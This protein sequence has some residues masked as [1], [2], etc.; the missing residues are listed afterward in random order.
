M[1]KICLLI[2]AATII[3]AACNPK[4]KKMSNNPL[5]NPFD[6]PFGIPPFEKIKNADY[7]PAFQE[8]IKLHNDEI[9]AIVNSKEEP[10][11]KNTIEALDF[12]GIL[13]SDIG[14]I[15]FALKSANTNDSI[16]KIAEEV[17]P[18]LAGHS[19]DI[20]LNE[21]LFKK[22]KAV[23]DKRESLKLNTEQSVLLKKTYDR[24]VRGGANLPVD[25]K[26]RFREINQKLSILQLKFGDNLV[27]ENNAF[28]LLL[29]KKEDLAGLPE[30]IISAAKEAAEAKGFKGKWLFTLDNPSR[31]PFLTYS[32][33]RDLREKI[34]RGYLKKGDNNNEYDNKKIIVEL[35]MLRQEKAKMLGYNNYA[36]YVIE[37]NMAKTPDKVFEMLNKVWSYTLPAVKKEAAELQKLIKSEGKTFKLEGWDW[38]YYSEK[39]RKA[40]YD[41]D[42][43]ATRPYFKLDNVK[44][45]MFLLAN[46]LY[47][48]TFEQ[49]KNAP[50]YSNEATVYEV[51]E[52]DGKHIGVF[53]MDPFPR[54]NKRG[55][56][57]MTNFRDQ[58]IMD[59]KET[60]PIV[61]NVCNFTR[62]TGDTP[63]LLTLD[64]VLTMFHEFGHG[65]HGLLSNCTYRS[66]SGTS[67]PRDFVEFGSQIMENWVTEPEFLKMYAKHYQTGEV[68][69]DELIKKI[70][71]SQYFN[72]GFI[73]AEYTA[74]ALLDMKWHTLTDI[75]ENFDVNAYEEKI[76]NEIGLIPEVAFRYRST[77]F[78]HSFTG[79]YSAGYYVYQWAA[80][81]EADAFQAFKENGLFDKKT[82]QSLRDN[83]ISRGSTE[84][85][86]TMYVN[87]RGSE[88]S[89][90]PLLRRLGFIK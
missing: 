42:E 55:G 13:L 88:P 60:R 7:L 61:M 84:D 79:E 12:S 39:L 65:L 85:A 38:W 29:D 24:F 58:Y 40:K 2:L 41:L 74:A 53:F 80:V 37:E 18:L 81:I 76:K 69:P 44:D 68:M 22:V 17:A 77:Y 3:F 14:S 43:E 5:L 72:Q 4:E 64:E 67:V 78:S 48:I 57:W 83:I 86:M 32:E 35:I 6:T 21:G 49:I 45:G 50:L 26:D 16:D 70:Q 10:N 11:F 34:Y 90:D 51:K 89:I 36:E 82:G 71:N 54:N 59:G 8:A 73:T 87:F 27:K 15:F 62:P 75:D 56:A 31:I 23:Y 46:K 47:G 52:A 28:E 9:D 25:K 63:S 66:L 30:S 33:R 19:D 20:A 1:K